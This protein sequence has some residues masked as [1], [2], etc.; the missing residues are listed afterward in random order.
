VDPRLAVVDRRLSEIGR[1][2]A[3]TGG[4]GGIGKSS[5]ASG[6][7]LALVGRGERVGLLDLDFCGPS[8]HVILGIRDA[9]P[10]EDGGLVPAL[11][12]GIRYLSIVGF[13]DHR[14]APL[15]GGDISNVMIELLAIARWGELDT[16]VIDMPPG[17]SDPLLDAARLVHRA[18]YLVVATPSL[19]ALET[20]RKALAVLQTLGLPVLG[21]VENMRRGTEPALEAQLGETGIPVLGSIPYEEAYEAAV[22]DIARLARTTF[23]QRM[24]V[25]A[26]GIQPV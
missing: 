20:V 19:V 8:T 14:P 13:I 5:V 15:R 6:L 10:V 26:E 22:G 18:E 25:I 1:I 17:F 4:K 21:I 3:V 9:P 24:G 12:H 23:M 7:A 16:L 11:V 2:V